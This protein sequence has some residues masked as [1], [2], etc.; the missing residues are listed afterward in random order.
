[1]E[2]TM[3]QTR[4]LLRALGTALALVAALAGCESGS[5]PP[6]TAPQAVPTELA[7]VWNAVTERGNAFSYE[8]ATDG[9]YRYVGLMRDGSQ[10]YTLQ[11]NGTVAVQADEVLFTPQHTLLTRTDPTLAEPTWTTSP[12]RP[13]RTVTWSV[14]GRTL[15]LVE[16][17]SPTSYQRE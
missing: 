7:G 15:T 17:G 10:Q 8:I 5:D 3:M 14:S 9:R 16:N 4:A 12:K 1:M 11:E 13:G 2:E 6:P